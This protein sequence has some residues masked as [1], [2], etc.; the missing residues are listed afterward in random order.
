MNIVISD[1]KNG[2]AY[3]KKTE[4]PVFLNYTIGDEIALDELG[5]QGYKAKIMGGS[6]LQGFPMHPAMIGSNRKKVLLV[7]GTGFKPEKRGE[8]KKISVRGN[9]V[10]NQISQL[11]IKVIAYGSKT[12]DELI[13]T[14]KKTDEKSD[15]SI[16]EEMVRASLE[17]V[18]KI[19]AKEAAEVAKSIKGKAKG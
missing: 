2:K 3:V 15:R 1:P 14:V 18:G 4:S 6:D 9:A 8:R 11:N 16:K 5:L 10:S 17:N 12:L 13:G 19:D 7:K